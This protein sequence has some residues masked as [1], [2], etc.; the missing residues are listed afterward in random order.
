[1]KTPKELD[2]LR[3]M[4]WFADTPELVEEMKAQGFDEWARHL[5][6]MNIYHK[7]LIAEIRKLRKQLK[8]WE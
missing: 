6:K 4:E 2:I 7:N 3:R 5:H 8:E 1:M